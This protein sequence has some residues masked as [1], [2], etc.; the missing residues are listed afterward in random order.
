MSERWV[1]LPKQ[2][3]YKG[4]IMMTREPFPKHYYKDKNNADSKS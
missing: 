1:I 2:S 4:Y 3:K